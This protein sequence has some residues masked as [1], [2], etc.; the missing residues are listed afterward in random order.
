MLTAEQVFTRFTQG[1]ATRYYRKIRNRNEA[2]DCRVL[3]LAAL[4]YLE[5]NWNKLKS[6]FAK[7][8]QKQKADNGQDETQKPTRKRKP[9]R[10]QSGFV[11]GW[12]G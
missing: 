2:L 3:A 8:I 7:A 5:P 11:H 12:K 9:A 10:R 1:V 6:R 4:E